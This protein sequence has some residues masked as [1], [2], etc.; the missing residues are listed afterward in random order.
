MV[1][2]H[3]FSGRLPI[4]T[5]VLDRFGDVLLMDVPR[6][7]KIGNRAG[8]LEDAVVGS[9]REYLLLAAGYL[10]SALIRSNISRT[11][12]MSIRLYLVL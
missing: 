11:V 10:F 3:Y 5:A 7:V 9:G 12:N 8:D 1:A 2:I 6:V 4:Q